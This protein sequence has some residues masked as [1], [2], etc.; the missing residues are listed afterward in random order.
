MPV[1][2]FRA[3]ACMIYDITPVAKPRQTRADV[4]KKRPAVLRYRAFADECRLKMTDVVLDGARVIFHV[5]MPRSW[6][7]KKKVEMNT[8]PHRQVP[9]ID[10]YAKALLDSLYESDSHVADICLSKRWAI[11]GSIEIS[12]SLCHGQT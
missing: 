8:R 7:K 1:P 5:P 3:G 9:D 12:R 6:S 2:I 4:W 11:E 10:N